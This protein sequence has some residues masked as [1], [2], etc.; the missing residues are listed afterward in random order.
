MAKKSKVQVE[1]EKRIEAMEYDIMLL[2]REALAAS[3]EVE[4]ALST[5]DVL[6]EILE[7]AK[8]NGED[9]EPDS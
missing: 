8:G 9:D 3:C 7:A 6:R 4:Q 1:M 5:L 2:E